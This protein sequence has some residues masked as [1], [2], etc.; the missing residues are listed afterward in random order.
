MEKEVSVV[1]RVK[2][3]S[4]KSKLISATYSQEHHCFVLLDDNGKLTVT[5]DVGSPKGWAKLGKNED[6]VLLEIKGEELWMGSAEG[7]LRQYSLLDL[8]I[9]RVV[10]CHFQ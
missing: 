1:R 7:V 4:T 9:K 3:P 2:I 5:D 6:I 10:A 8:K